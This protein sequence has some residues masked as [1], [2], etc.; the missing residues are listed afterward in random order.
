MKKSIMVKPKK[1]GRPPA[2]GRDPL[3]NARMPP[4]LIESIDEWAAA[5]SDGSRSEAIRRLVELGLA[6]SGPAKM[7]S[8]KA[9]AKASDMAGDQIDKLA[10]PAMPEEER[11]A[12][13]RRL[14]KGPREFRDMRGDQAKPK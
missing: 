5:N 10:N 14:L 1:R 13:K 11:R 7:I 4:D 12:R 2:G 8:P 6:G 9:A 3:V